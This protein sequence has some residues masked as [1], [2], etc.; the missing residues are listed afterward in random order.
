MKLENL[1]LLLTQGYRSQEAIIKLLEQT[2]DLLDQQFDTGETMLHIAA[3]YSCAIL[4]YYLMNKKPDPE[5]WL[6][7]AI[8]R[9]FSAVNFAMVKKHPDVLAVLIGVMATYATPEM[10]KNAETL[11][12][13]CKKDMSKESW[14]DL[15]QKLSDTTFLPSMHKRMIDAIEGNIISK[16]MRNTSRLFSAKPMDIGIIDSCVHTPSF[17]HTKSD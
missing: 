10:T 15:E 12:N 13:H 4:L 5:F 17:T 3:E 16:I 14:D 6:K 11:K 9:G 1:S 8:D 7:T 2:P